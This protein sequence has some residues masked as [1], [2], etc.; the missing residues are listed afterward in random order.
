G[1]DGDRD[2]NGPPAGGSSV[3]RQDALSQTSPDDD[4]IDLN[5]LHQ[6]LI[7]GESQQVGFIDETTDPLNRRLVSSVASLPCQFADYTL[8]AVIGRGGMGVVYAG[9]Q[10]KLDRQVAVKMIRSGALAS[11]Q[12][13][14]RFYAEARSAAQLDHPNIVTVYQCGEY[15]GH[16]FF[17]M[18]FVDGDDLSK[19]TRDG[20]LEPKAAARYVRDAA[21]AIQYAHENGIVHRDLKPANLLVDQNDNV[22]ITDFGLAKSIDTESSLTATGAAIGT[23]SYMSPEQAAGQIENA[24]QSTDVYS[25]GAILFAITT[26]RPPFKAGSVVQTIMQVI[27]RPPPSA[28]SINPELKGDLATIIDRCLQ[29]SPDQRYRSAEDLANDLERF[30]IDAPIEARPMSATRRA[31]YWLLGV[32]IVGAVLDHRVVEPTNAHHWVQR[33]LISALLLL[34]L[35]M[36]LVAV[37]SSVWYKNRMPRQLTI[38]AGVEGGAYFGLA[39]EISELINANSKCDAQVIASGGSTDNLSRLLSGQAGLALVQSDAVDSA[40]I[41]VVAPM[42]FEVVHILVRGDLGISTLAELSGRK[43]KVGSQKGGSQRIAR[44]VLQY[45]GL[46]MGDIELDESPLDPLVAPS[47]T[48]D[49]V[50]VVTRPGASLVKELL[51]GNRYRLFDMRDAWQ[52]T[53]DEPSFHVYYVDDDHYPDCDLPADGIRAVAT[54]AFLVT[55]SDASSALVKLI[56]TQLFETDRAEKLGIFDASRAAHWKELAWHAAAR[57]FFGPYR[58]TIAE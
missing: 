19:M 1:G 21:R 58:S 43:V 26:G 9:R 14:A 27:H 4:T 51:A 18:D 35:G 56:L 12:E 41:S 37:P 29:K 23:P 10:Q 34:A 11:D 44:S 32:P 52:F 5:P 36:I 28:S 8:D 24:P 53:I 6:T 45:A 2:N 30:L 38:A 16:H 47:D 42:Y 20:P 57:E 3:N 15:E 50:I 17:S 39:D 13:V 55:K 54:T 7:D 48:A 49:A 22:R 46:S 25:L 33:G 31:W 40:E